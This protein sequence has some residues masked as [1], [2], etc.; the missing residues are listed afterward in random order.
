MCY[1]IRM[2]AELGA[3]FLCAHC[4]I[5]GQLQ[6]DTYIASWL[7]VLKNDARYRTIEA[8]FFGLLLVAPNVA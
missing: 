1:I 3:A 2:I 8:L 7:E 6:H 5:D 4:S